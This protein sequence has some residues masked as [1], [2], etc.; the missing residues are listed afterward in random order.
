MMQVYLCPRVSVDVA[1][2]CCVLLFSPLM[3][4]AMS[5]TRGAAG[6]SCD[7][8]HIPRVSKYLEQD[9]LEFH[10]QQKTVM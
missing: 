4:P 10:D 5:E 1:R 7:R 2:V 9:N 3:M 6:N 8:T